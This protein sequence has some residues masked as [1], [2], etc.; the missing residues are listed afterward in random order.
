MA[1]WLSQD[2][3]ATR[4]MLPATKT[5]GA[6]ITASH[7]SRSISAINDG[8]LPDDEHNHSAAPYYHWWPKEG[9]TEWIVYEFT[10]PQDISSSSVFW[11]DDGP[12]GGCRVPK[13]WK[14]Y[15][16]DAD[17]NWQPVRNV[18]DYTTVKG[19]NNRVRFAP[20]KTKAVK[21]EVVLPEKNAAGLFEWSVE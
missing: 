13:N 21:M 20:V 7:E 18:G 5:T 14:L 16:R 19:A 17:G 15:Y 2:L 9:T 8:L 1:V 3:S 6:K 10:S 12:W 11:Y 4:P